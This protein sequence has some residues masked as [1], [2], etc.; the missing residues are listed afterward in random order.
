MQTSS[1]DAVVEVGGWIVEPDLNAASIEY[2]AAVA[3][4]LSVR[5]C[6]RY[7][8]KNSLYD[9]LFCFNGCGASPV[10]ENP[11]P[12]HAT[13]GVRCAFGLCIFDYARG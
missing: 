1:S 4:P 12:C 5:L 3:V 2:C 6:G 9:H 10:S 13:I 8:E 11:I 7:L